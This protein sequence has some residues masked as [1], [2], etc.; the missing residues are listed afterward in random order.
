MERHYPKREFDEDDARGTVK[1]KP[2]SDRPCIHDKE[3]IEAL[4][5]V[6]RAFTQRTKENNGDGLGAGGTT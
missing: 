6:P 2:S 5:G 4:R 1:W 3:D